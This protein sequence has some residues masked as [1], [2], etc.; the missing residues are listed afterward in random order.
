MLDV[1]E[2]IENVMDKSKMEERKEM[3]IELIDK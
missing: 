3:D 1:R 2:E